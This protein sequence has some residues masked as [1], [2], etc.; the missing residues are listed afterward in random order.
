MYNK[1]KHFQPW[2]FECGCGCGEGPGKMHPEFLARLDRA[3]ARAEIPF[4]V[5]S[6]YRCPE[7][8]KRIGTT[9]DSAH[10]RGYAAD[11]KAEHS[12]DR[13]MILATAIKE[14][15]NRI[16]IAEGFIHLDNDPDKPE[17]VCWVY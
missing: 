17:N 9:A 13:E 5:N 11:I 15:F 6:G 8:N 4:H 7:Y 3:R 14:G 2:E 12:R 10:T 16:G 1:I